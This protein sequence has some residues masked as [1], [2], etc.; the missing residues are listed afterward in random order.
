M[1]TYATW[2]KIILTRKL[3]PADTSLYADRDLWID[4]GRLYLVDDT[5]VEWIEFSGSPTLSGTEYIYPNLVRGLSQTADPATAWTG[6]TW[7]A[8]TE[9]KL[10]AMHD[11]LSDRQEGSPMPQKTTVQLNART[12]K[13]L[14]E[15]FWDTTQGWPVYY[16]GSDYVLFPN[17]GSIGNSTETSTGVVEKATS[18]ESISWT[19]TWTVWPLFVAPSDIAINTQSGTH[20]YWHSTDLSDTYTATFTPTLTPTAWTL[21]RVKFDTINTG[22]CTLNAIAIKL[23]NGLDPSNW[24]IAAGWTYELIYDGTNY[25]LGSYVSDW[26]LHIAIKDSIGD[27]VGKSTGTNYLAAES[28]F[29]NAIC[30]YSSWNNGW[31][32]WYVW[33]A[34]PATTLIAQTRVD[35]WGNLTNGWLCFPVKKWNYYRVDTTW[36][37]ASATVYFTPNK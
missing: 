1:Q 25:I 35:G 19:N 17:W 10:V 6:L 28:W 18:A 22:A 32:N 29:I 34:D 26:T 15:I 5:Q 16:N 13:V 9:A 31:L 24:D 8:V 7:L 3:Q 33:A 12:G 2:G 30:T 23:Q 37:L 11:Q 27:V 36:T 20:I 21:V 14:W 4:K